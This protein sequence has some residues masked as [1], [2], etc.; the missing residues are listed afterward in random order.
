MFDII[1]MIKF[2]GNCNQ[3]ILISS[4]TIVGAGSSVLGTGL[5]DDVLMNLVPFILIVAS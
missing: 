1:L 2:T 4:L 3:I 5:S